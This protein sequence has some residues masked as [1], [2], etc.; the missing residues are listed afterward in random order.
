[1]KKLLFIPLL[2]FIGQN[3]AFMAPVTRAGES[4]AQTAEKRATSLIDHPNR[5]EIFSMAATGYG[6]S[7]TTFWAT[8]KYFPHLG[9]V[10]LGRFGIPL[11]AVASLGLSKAAGY[12][13]L[14]AYF[15]T[16]SKGDRS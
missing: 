7:F 13:P 16:K 4:L 1:M 10:R 5:N 14:I 6:L 9:T 8:T 15:Y 2:L 11:K 3:W 12:S